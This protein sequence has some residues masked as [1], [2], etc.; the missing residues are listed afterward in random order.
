MCVIGKQIFINKSA[1]IFTKEL[2]SI[3]ELNNKAPEKFHATEK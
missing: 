2:I 3:N 1:V